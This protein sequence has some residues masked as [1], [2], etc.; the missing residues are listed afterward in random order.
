MN[1]STH[2]TSVG[3]A[4]LLKWVVF[5]VIMT[6]MVETYCYLLFDILRKLLDDPLR[7]FFAPMTTIVLVVFAVL[8]PVLQ[9]RQRP[10]T[11]I[12]LLYAG[13]IAANAAY[14]VYL[15]SAAAHG[16][17]LLVVLALVAA[18]LYGMPLLA[19]IVVA[20]LLLARLLFVRLDRWIVQ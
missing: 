5:V 13:F 3:P 9:R 17:A 15:W 20:D 14:G 4:R 1:L 18:H 8:Y 12:L 7:Y 16:T 10:L 6:A 19:S 2:R 11:R